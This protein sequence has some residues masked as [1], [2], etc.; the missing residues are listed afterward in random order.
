VI[1]FVFKDSRLS[2][3]VLPRLS[4]MMVQK[5]REKHYVAAAADKT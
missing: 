3:T 2:C 4:G 1:L 5:G